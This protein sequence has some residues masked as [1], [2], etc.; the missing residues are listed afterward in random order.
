[1]ILGVRRAAYN[2]LLRLEKE[3][4]YS[5]LETDLT[6]KREALSPADRRL[7]TLLVYGVVE[8]RITLDYVLDRFSKKKISELDPEVRCLL[9]LAAYQILFCDRIPQSAAVNESVK[10]AKEVRASAAGYVNGVLRSL[11]SGKDSIQYPDKEKQPV[12]WLSVKYSYPEEM[13]RLF[14]KY[15][16]IERTAKL[17]AAFE[18][19]DYMTLRVNTLKITRQALAEQL[20]QHGINSEYT[21][22][23]PY[24]LKVRAAVSDLSELAEGLCFVQ[25]EASQLCAMVLGANA[26]ETVI[27]TCACPGG[28]SFSLAMEMENKG[29]LYSFDLHA[30]KLSLVEKGAEKLGI[31]IIETACRSGAVYEP[32]LAESAD[33]MLMDLPCSGLGVMAKKPDLRFK[34]VEDIGRLPEVQFA[35]LQNSARYLK[36]GG[37]LVVSTCTLAKAENEDLIRRFLEN[38]TDFTLVP[39]TVGGLD[40]PCGMLQ[41]YP[42]IH[43][44]DGF[45][46]AL[47]EKKK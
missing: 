44:T 2:S 45:F 8:R 26:N 43:G 40:A 28:K 27:D 34:K 47:L 31:S 18:K 41:L 38:D 30:N 32:T 4:R 13:C 3:S 23:S 21:P 24:G 9:R 16:G 29:K 37:R 1:M 39:F 25:D 7:Y 12:L 14:V 11:C 20:A 35:I 6:L 36:K 10:I 33:R 19:Q 15:H 22:Y 46:I 5:N 17:F 42:D